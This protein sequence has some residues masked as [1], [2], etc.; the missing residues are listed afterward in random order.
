MMVS[1]VSHLN[2][3]DRPTTRLGNKPEVFAS[4]SPHI[5][6]LDDVGVLEPLQYGELNNHRT[7][8]RTLW[9]VD[10]HKSRCT[11]QRRSTDVR[12]GWYA[13]AAKL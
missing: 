7:N 2:N 11:V 1:R 4:K 9:F 10:L 13:D 6:H 5:D 3:P 12:A 8:P